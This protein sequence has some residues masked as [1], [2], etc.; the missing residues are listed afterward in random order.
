MAYCSHNFVSY[1]KCLLLDTN[2]L[3]IVHFIDGDV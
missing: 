1:L 2:V 3:R